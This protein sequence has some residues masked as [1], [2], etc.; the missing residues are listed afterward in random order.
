MIVP[1]SYSSISKF[2]QCP[3]AYHEQ[4]VLKSVKF[5]PSAALDRGNKIH[6]ALEAS[7]KT[8]APVPDDI[9][10]PDGLMDSLRDSGAVAEAPL[11]VD[12]Q[13]QQV[14]FF[15]K[16]PLLRGKIDVLSID[17]DGRGVEM[18]DWKTGK[19]RPDETQADIYA[20][21]IR[22]VVIKPA[23]PVKFTW[24]YVE[25]SVKKH[26]SI[27]VDTGASSR[28]RSSIETIYRASRFDERPS[29]LCKWCDVLACKFNRREET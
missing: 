4:Y 15:S 28:V 19:Y 2:F 20:A 10:L 22:A 16:H 14:E 18:I 5:K 9:W 1:Q 8:G 25:P 27:M 21:L 3:R 6:A 7:L 11:A 23:L 24:V 12:S 13:W 26:H 17:G 29:P